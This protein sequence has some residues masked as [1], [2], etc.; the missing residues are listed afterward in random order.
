MYNFIL[1][2]I[3]LM[4]WKK[5]GY[6]YCKRMIWKKIFSKVVVFYFRLF[7]NLIVIWLEGDEV[8]FNEKR[9]VGKIIGLF[10]FFFNNVQVFFI[11]KK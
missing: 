9:L 8:R 3:I 7:L 2:V 4:Q 1:F 6:V 11:R 10:L 5:L